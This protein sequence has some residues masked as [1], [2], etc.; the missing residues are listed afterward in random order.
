MLRKELARVR[1]VVAVHEGFDGVRAFRE[2]HHELKMT[3]M[4]LHGS[5]S[6]MQKSID[7]VALSLDRSE[8]QAMRLLAAKFG[9]CRK[10]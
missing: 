9:N 3:T 7:K 8:S 10:L 5:H 2:F 1:Q 4:A 6:V